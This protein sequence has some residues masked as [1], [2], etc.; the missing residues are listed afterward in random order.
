MSRS[1]S[2]FKYANETSNKNYAVRIDYGLS[3]TF[4][5]SSFYSKANDPLSAQITGLDIRPDNLWEVYGAG[6]RWKFL[7]NKDLSLSINGS[8]ESW[9]VG[10][11]GS[12]SSGRD[13]RDNASSNIFNDS[14][15]RV[16]TQ[17]LIGSISLP[18]TWHVNK[19]W[20]FTFSPGISFLP[21]SQGKGQA[22]WR[23]L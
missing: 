8:L 13:S 18:L 6:A 19:D 22:G 21:A 3:N 11:G 17:N 16:E 14:G 12:D 5:I 23:I 9:T 10:S 4:Q 15:K 2:P 7:T 20:Q 1:I